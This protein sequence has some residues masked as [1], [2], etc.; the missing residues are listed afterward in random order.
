MFVKWKDDDTTEGA[1]RLHHLR[2]TVSRSWAEDKYGDVA[3]NFANEQEELGLV[4]TEAS[5][6]FYVHEECAGI[7]I[8]SC[9]K[10]AKTLI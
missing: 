6:N 9:M 4:A 2:L 5:S 1:T 8:Y 7:Y 3:R 10:L